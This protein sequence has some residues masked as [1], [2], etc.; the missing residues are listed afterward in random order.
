M[1]SPRHQEDKRIVLLELHSDFF[2]QGAGHMVPEDTPEYAYR[3]FEKFL[4]D[5]PFVGWKRLP[6]Q[7]HLRHICA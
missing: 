5:E 1:S 2:V 3:M 7:T 6:P 4:N